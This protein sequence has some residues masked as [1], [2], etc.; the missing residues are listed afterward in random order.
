VCVFVNSFPQVVELV[1]AR[2]RQGD[3]PQAIAERLVKSAIEKGST[4]NVSVIIV[5]F[6]L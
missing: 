1:F 2:L 5:R 6:L 4:D 3:K